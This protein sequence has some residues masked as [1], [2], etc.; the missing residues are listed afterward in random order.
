[1]HMYWLG[2]YSCVHLTQ[3]S[4]LLCH[5]FCVCFIKVVRYSR[6]ISV[7]KVKAF[8]PNR[9]KTHEVISSVHLPT[10]NPSP[11]N[12]YHQCCQ[13]NLIKVE[14]K[15][16]DIARIFQLLVVIICWWLWHG[17]FTFLLSV[18]IPCIIVAFSVSRIK[19]DRQRRQH[20][21]IVTMY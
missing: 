16:S 6:W 14:F 8:I 7:R 20:R 3:M 2:S 19:P 13:S 15:S 21:D 5:I 18:L 1:M 9:C 4:R 10:N 11:C 12:I 17:C